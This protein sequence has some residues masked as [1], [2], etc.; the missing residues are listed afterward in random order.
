M[1]SLMVVAGSRVP[2]AGGSLSPTFVA[3][4]TASAATYTCDPAPPSGVQAGDLMVAFVRSIG[5][6][7][8]PG[9]EGGAGGW[10]AFALPAVGSMLCFHRT[11]TGSEPATYT[12][13][14][15]DSE[16]T[17]V[18]CTIVAYRPAPGTTLTVTG[19][20]NTSASGTDHTTDSITPG[21]DNAMLIVAGSSAAGRSWTA[22]AG[23]DE[24][25]DSGTHATIGVFDVIQE[26]AALVSKTA[27][28][29]SA[30]AAV[31]AIVALT[32]TTV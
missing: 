17:A 14:D 32:P 19:D 20:L 22:P 23:M 13:T 28:I 15:F 21:A 12:A 11:A 6:G 27:V 24:R 29:D 2:A 18:R 8:I 16:G 4:S 10:T 9:I 26:T 7:L 31:M 25:A 1:A 5:A 30:V 3:A